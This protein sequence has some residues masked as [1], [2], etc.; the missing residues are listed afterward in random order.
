MCSGTLI[1]EKE[2]GTYEQRGDYILPCLTLP[3]E[4]E[5]PIGIWGQRH[6]RYLKEYRRATYI[7]LLTSDRRDRRI[8]SQ[9]AYAM[10]MADECAESTG[11]GSDFQ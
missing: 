3:T 7:T 1:F 6:L 4:K 8:E 2:G 10:G 5:Q 9:R 11:G